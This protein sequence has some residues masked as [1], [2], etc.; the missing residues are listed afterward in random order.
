MQITFLGTVVGGF[1]AFDVLPK[2]SGSLFGSSRQISTTTNLVLLFSLV[3]MGVVDGG[4]GGLGVGQEP[5][6]L[7]YDHGDCLNQESVGMQQYTC[8][9]ANGVNSA[10]LGSSCLHGMIVSGKIVVVFFR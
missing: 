8:D 6:Q 3:P 2:A 9:N 1:A 5:E 4:L 7:L 10:F